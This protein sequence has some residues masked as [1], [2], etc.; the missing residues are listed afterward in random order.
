MPRRGDR[1]D[2]RSRFDRNRHQPAIRMGVHAVSAS[3]VSPLGRA[4]D[5]A[6]GTAV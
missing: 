5:V 2:A 4:G 1:R 6:I 3:G